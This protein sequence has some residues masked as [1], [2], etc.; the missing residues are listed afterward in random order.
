MGQR[1]RRVLVVNSIRDECARQN[2]TPERLAAATG[3]DLT[4]LLHKLKGERSFT[5]DELETIALA[6][7]VTVDS[8]LG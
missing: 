1:R 5:V 4:A 8:L 3:L 7:G 6:L 2:V